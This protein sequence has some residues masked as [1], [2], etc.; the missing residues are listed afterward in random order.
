MISQAKCC[1]KKKDILPPKEKD[2]FVPLANPK[3][4][5]RCS[6]GIDYLLGW[7]IEERKNKSRVRGFF[8][9]VW[10]TGAYIITQNKLEWERAQIQFQGK[11]TSA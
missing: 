2:T 5:R 7:N 3:L 10:H 8:H 1:K 9:G 11:R 4:F 6:D